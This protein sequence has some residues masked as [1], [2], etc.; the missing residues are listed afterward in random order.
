MDAATRQL[1]AQ[2]YQN[3]Q[4]LEEQ[5]QEQR[6]VEQAKVDAR[7]QDIL[8]KMKTDEEKRLELEHKENVQVEI[9]LTRLS[10]TIQDIAN[11]NSKNIDIIRLDMFLSTFENLI[12][13]SIRL[14]IVKE[15]LPD[16]QILV[17]KLMFVITEKNIKFTSTKISVYEAHII[18]WLPTR[19][20]KLCALVSMEASSISVETMNID[21]DERL[22]RELAEQFG[23]LGM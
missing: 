14:I 21:D 3:E 11:M 23:T 18:A 17:G 8:Q 20:E 13:E 4:K 9:A 1:L 5:R 2:R 19:V 15:K 10:K 22:A 16:L 12:K 7:I 6:R